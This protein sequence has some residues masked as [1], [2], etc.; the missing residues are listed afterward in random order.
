MAPMR[1]MAVVLFLGDIAFLAVSLWLSLYVRAFKV[2]AWSYFGDHVLGFIPVFLVSIGIFFIAGLYEKQTR[3]I[4]SF[5]TGRIFGAQIAS[6]LVGVVCFFFLPLD[7]A[8]K[9]VLV[10]YLIISVVLVS[11]WRFLVA[12]RVSTGARVQA[13]LVA[14]GEAATELAEE[15]NSTARYAMEI[16]EHITVADGEDVSA[17][18]HA[19]VAKG[20]RMLIVDTR[21][22]VLGNTQPSLYD[23]TFSQVSV[24]EF[25]TLYEDV[26][27]RVP[28]DHIDYAWI[29]ECLPKRHRLYEVGKRA[30]DAVLALV[31]MVIAVPILI[32]PVLVLA[33]SGGHPFIFSGRIGKDGHLVRIIKLRTKLFYD[34]GDPEKQ[35]INRETT[36]GTFLRRTRIDELPQLVNILRGELSFIGPR[37][38][39][40]T[41]AAV[42]QKE[43]PYYDVRHLI[44]PGLSGW[45]QIRDYDAPRGGADIERTRRKL[46]YDLYYLTRRSFVL[47]LVI[48][49]KT[50]RALVA[51]SGR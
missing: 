10:L 30:F 20:A 11:V 28:L 48:T 29:L 46:S 26:F 49:L 33:C 47:D 39:L 36:F 44:T 17:R 40:P 4:R 38:E 8:P 6:I 13:I 34:G 23:M 32:I 21:N 35:K 25:T 27:D 43:V 50:I 31:G 45:A 41:I 2:P 7:I 51:V 16:A 12:P 9:T 24:I 3:V 37:P 1:R 19:A 18:V 15:I 42:Y 5:M 14:N 22:P